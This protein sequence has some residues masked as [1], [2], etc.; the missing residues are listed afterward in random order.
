M[1]ITK[2]NYKY[3]YPQIKSSLSN[4]NFIALDFEF[5]GTSLKK[6]LV[7]TRYDDINLRYYKL[8]ENIKSFLPLQAGICGVKI[9]DT[10]STN[11]EL[12]PMNFY[13][14]PDSSPS[15]N[16][17]KY[18][19]DIDSINFLASNSFDFN[20]TFYDGIR[21]ISL[22]DNYSKDSTISNISNIRNI[23]DK[24]FPPEAKTIIYSVYPKLNALVN[25]FYESHN[26]FDY[27]HPDNSIQIEITHT[28]KVLVDYLISSLNTLF[29]TPSGDKLIFEVEII[30]KNIIQNIL[31]IK[32][33]NEE[34]LKKKSIELS[35]ER[36]YKRISGWLYYQSLVLGESGDEL[37]KMIWKSVLENMNENLNLNLSQNEI[38]NEN[39]KI[40]LDDIKQ[41]LN[42]KVD[43]SHNNNDNNNNNNNNND[44]IL[45]L[46]TQTITSN[47]QSESKL[48]FTTII[49]D[50]IH[51][52][53][54]LIFHNGLLDLIQLVDKFIEP[55][56]ETFD[57]FRSI[58]NKYFPSIYDTKYLIENNISLKSLY[59]DS[60]LEVVSKKITQTQYNIPDEYNEYNS[61]QKSHE[62]GY[63]AMMT[64]L[65][66]IEIFKHLFKDIT[67]MA[68][69]YNFENCMAIFKNKLL[70]SNMQFSCDLN[71]N[72]NN[73]SNSNSS[74]ENFKDNLSLEIF[75]LTD[76]PE[77]ITNDE[78]KNSFN[79]HYNVKPQVNKLFGMNI[80]YAVF[81]S[82]EQKEEFM[83]RVSE[84]SEYHNLT[85]DVIGLL[86]LEGYKTSG[87]LVRYS[88][89]L[90][91]VRNVK[92]EEVLI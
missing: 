45:Q 29:T 84:F 38:L 71:N 21:Y 34:M 31:S 80:A 46:I 70:F 20:K 27:N 62:A 13:I 54:P 9:N 87:Y 73:N 68:D 52:K 72:S 59:G 88:K 8:K 61:Q 56:P 47:G 79:I 69:K 85:G 14:F 10:I 7:N 36:N 19:F 32:L 83:R 11:I 24:V 1:K 43:K 18:H 35:S 82:T 53:K 49:Q 12:Q 60:S 6:E 81:T 30:K 28:R 66:F 16:K 51:L 65:A 63:D 3:L 25:K 55:V 89:Y 90:D 33:T 15:R 26:N 77:I 64:S 91:M 39:K 37:H 76:L 40:G 4:S 86:P 92:N 48:G 74:N 57:E 5:S 58:V 50:L 41:A 42:Y 78:I 22:S 17:N 2:L 67:M 23:K 44:N 75:V